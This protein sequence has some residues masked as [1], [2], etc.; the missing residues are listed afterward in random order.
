MSS[1]VPDFN[2]LS[3]KN[4]DWISDLTGM[5]A[6]IATG[7]VASDSSELKS[8][9]GRRIFVTAK[10]PVAHVERSSSLI[11]RGFVVVD[12]AISFEWTPSR[13]IGAASAERPPQSLQPLE[14]REAEAEDANAVA[15]LAGRAFVLSRFHLDPDFPNAQARRIKTEWARNLALRARGDGCLV[16]VRNGQVVGFLGFSKCDIGVSSFVI[17][18]VAVDPDAHRNGVGKSLIIHLLNDAARAGRVV[19]VGTQAANVHSVRLYET[20]GFRYTG[21]TQVLHAH[22]QR[23]QT[24]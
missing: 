13:I 12:T 8:A 4:D 20:L 18:L 15:T 9:P 22:D 3:L 1:K 21:A 23:E 16:A 2:G 17:D 5:T 11:R 10:V 6:L 24:G 7:E 19:T 14:V